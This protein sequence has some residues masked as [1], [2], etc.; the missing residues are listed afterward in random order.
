VAEP[1]VASTYIG[2]DRLAELLQDIASSITHAVSSAGSAIA[3]QL[4]YIRLTLFEMTA[5]LNFIGLMILIAAVIIA[6]AVIAAGFLKTKAFYDVAEALI[7]AIVREK[8]RRDVEVEVEKR[9]EEER[10]RFEER[11]RG[12]RLEEEFVRALG[13]R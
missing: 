6:V 3:Q 11:E 4:E 12:R 5:S 9:G 13:G 10:Q 2:L 1:A 7:H 8:V